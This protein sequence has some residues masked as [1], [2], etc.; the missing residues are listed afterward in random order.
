VILRV[1]LLIAACVILET[2]EQIF[3]RLAGRV[4]NNRAQYWKHVAPAVAVHFTRL[5][6]WYVLL[7]T[8]K[9]GVA[10]PLL[11]VNYIAIA[12]TGRLVFGERVDA[13]RWLG[14]ALV[15]AG[16]TLVAGSL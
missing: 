6:F 15:V 16:F 3:Y 14:T 4:E 9:L 12:L 5:A 10:I 7:G 8:V 13:R 2:F 1:F 11:G